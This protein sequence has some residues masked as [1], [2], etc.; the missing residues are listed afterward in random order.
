MCGRYALT[1]K[2]KEALEQLRDLIGDDFEMSPRYNIA[3]QQTAPVIRRLDDK[4]KLE[5]LRWGFRPAWL[6]D[7]NKAQI[8]ARAETVFESKMFKHSA[9]NRRC[10]IP[11]TGWYEWQARVGGKQ[12]HYFHKRDGGLLLLAG[13]WTTW[14]GEDGKEESNYAIITTEAN[15]LAAPIHN[16]MPVILNEAGREAW[17]DPANKAAPV[18]DLL[19][20]PYEG[21]ELDVYP[22][23]TYVNAP[24]NSSEQCI[25]LLQG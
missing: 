17:L 24:K 5:E 21:D 4:M 6:K 12:P 13:I 2:D 7:K 15:L 11:A 14:H 23:S 10:L 3:P 8:N 19:L 22:V 9:L 16:R 25:E 18:L 20:S 1:L